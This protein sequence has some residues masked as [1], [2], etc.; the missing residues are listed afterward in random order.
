M[1]RSRRD[2]KS[3]AAFMLFAR[4]A[5]NPS[6][7]PRRFAVSGSPVSKAAPQDG[8]PAFESSSQRRLFSA[9][10]SRVVAEPGFCGFCW[11]SC[12]AQ[13]LSHRMSKV[14]RSRPSGSANRSA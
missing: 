4:F 3:D 10:A 6:G 7:A 12:G 14:A 5:V 13:P 8:E 11:L 9:S 2:T 1:V